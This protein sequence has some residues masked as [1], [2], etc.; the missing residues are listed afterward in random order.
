MT[1][2]LAIDHK[3]EILIQAGNLEQ[4]TLLIIAASPAPVVITN[5]TKVA[6]SNQGKLST[7]ELS[8]YLG[9]YMAWL[10]FNAENR[11][12]TMIDSV[13]LDGHLIELKEK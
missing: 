4:H 11:P 1:S 8:K 3:T 10:P 6:P 5:R 9:Y 12:S 2:T 13:G 7:R